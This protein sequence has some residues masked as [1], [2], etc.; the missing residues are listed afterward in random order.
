MAALRLFART[1][2]VTMTVLASALAPVAAGAESAAPPDSFLTLA[3]HENG[4]EASPRTATL[5]CYPTGGT[6]PHADEACKSLAS[7][8]GDI[9]ALPREQKMC[10]MEYQ[11]VTLTAHGT[12][13]GKPT[14][15]EKS[16]SNRCVAAA[17][18]EKVFAF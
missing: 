1:S 9:N 5:A 11:P 7:V 4:R 10:T 17:Q 12:W 15:F 8:G 2:L 18:T 16:Y 3:V 13:R 14:R 6:H